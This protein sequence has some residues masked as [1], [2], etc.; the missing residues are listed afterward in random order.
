[1]AGYRFA[2][3]LLSGPCNLQC[4]TCIGRLVAGELPPNLDLFPLRG[5]DRFVT[6]LRDHDIVQVSVTGTNTEPLLYHHTGALLDHLRRQVPGVQLSLHTNGIL[7]LQR[8]ED[9]HRYDRATISVPSLN[10]ETCRAMTGRAEPVP[11]AALLAR[12]RI[13][14]KVSTL[15][16]AH[17]VHE[18]PALLARL[19]ELDLTRAVLRRCVGEAQRW[20]LLTEHRPVRWFG[21]NPVYD[22]D[23]LEVSIWDF[24]ATALDCVNLYSDGRLED[25]YRLRR[26]VDRAAP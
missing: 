20:P 5:L 25:S 1:M 16:T 17:N 24:A 19:R 26:E 7:A 22:L 18:L 8:L 13:P 11:L 9:F 4:P 3:V 15:V 10:A 23:G 12:A 14:I 2:N 6:A 21:G